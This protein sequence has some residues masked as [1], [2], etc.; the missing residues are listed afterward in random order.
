MRNDIVVFLLY[1]CTVIMVLSWIALIS[2]SVLVDSPQPA[3]SY[4]LTGEVNGTGLVTYPLRGE[5]Y[6]EHVFILI[7]AR[8]ELQRAENDARPQKYSI[9]KND[10]PGHPG[11]VLYGR[12]STG[13]WCGQLPPNGTLV[14][15]SSPTGFTRD[16]R[17][18]DLQTG[19][20][21]MSNCP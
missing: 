15:I 5:R 4:A 17:V 7:V 8:D 2:V 13:K 3:Q 9:G 20:V 16:V 10:F 14:K 11:H 6:S 12:H 21:Y 18:F 19:D 1:A